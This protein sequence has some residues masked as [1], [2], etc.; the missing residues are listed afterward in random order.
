MRAANTLDNDIIQNHSR[1]FNSIDSNPDTGQ[2]CAVLRMS[3]R[4]NQVQRAY[5][6]CWFVVQEALEHALLVSASMARMVVCDFVA[7]LQT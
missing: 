1:I 3:R 6:L 2:L 4:R 5:C 7:I